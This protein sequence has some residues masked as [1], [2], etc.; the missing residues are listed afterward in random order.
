MKTNR[1]SKSYVR[2]SLGAMAI[3]ALIIIHFASQFIFFRNEKPS[4]NTGSIN[5]QSV[6]VKTE[7]EA[8]KPDIIKT[9]GDDEEETAVA[10]APPNNQPEPRFAPSRA[11]IRK[12]ESRESKSERLRRL[13]KVLTGV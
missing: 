13:E 9:P 11:I 8:K 4:L 12:K 6:E 5:E 3:F 2:P 1:V 10:T 7:N